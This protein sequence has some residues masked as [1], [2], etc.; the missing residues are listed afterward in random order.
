MSNEVDLPKD[1]QT[2]ADSHTIKGHVYNCTTDWHTLT[3]TLTPTHSHLHTHTHPP[4]PTHTHT[5]TYSVFPHELHGDLPRCIRHDLVD[6]ATVPDQLTPLLC[7][8]DRLA[9]AAVCELVIAH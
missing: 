8:H 1:R 2:R 9:L 4:P 3:H 6:I 7:V 5:H